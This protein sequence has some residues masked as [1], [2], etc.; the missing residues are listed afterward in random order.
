MFTVR[1]ASP[2]NS[3]WE[4][5]TGLFRQLLLWFCLFCCRIGAIVSIDWLPVVVVVIEMA[6]ATNNHNSGIIVS[7]CCCNTADYCCPGQKSRLHSLLSKYNNKTTTTEKHNI[8]NC[9]KFLF[10]IN[11]YCSIKNNFFY[12][13]PKLNTLSDDIQTQAINGGSLL[14][15]AS[16]SFFL[17]NGIWDSFSLG[18]Y[19]IYIW[20]GKKKNK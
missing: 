8:C 18:N 4:A 19:F 15:S 20:K 14:L 1:V 13:Q 10:T 17:H 16:K 12:C 5:L 11:L 3:I 2:F 7:G 9:F 6:M